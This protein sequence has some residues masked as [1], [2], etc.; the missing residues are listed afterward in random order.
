MPVPP[1]QDPNKVAEPKVACQLVQGPCPLSSH[2][3]LRH[4]S[5]LV[6]GPCPSSSHFHLRH[7]SQLVW[8]P[9]LAAG[10]VFP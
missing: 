10:F 1:A 9:Y 2:V 5:Q 3:H 6:Q 7:Q 8:G 4:Q